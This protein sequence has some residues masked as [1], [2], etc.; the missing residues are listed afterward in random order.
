[1]LISMTTYELPPRKALLIDGDDLGLKEG[2]YVVS[3]DTPAYNAVYKQ[4]VTD[5]VTTGKTMPYADRKN[6]ALNPATG[7]GLVKRVG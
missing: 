4:C 3:P 1:M 5:H 6:R 2:L 7:R